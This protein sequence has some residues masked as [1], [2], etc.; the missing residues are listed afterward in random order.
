MNKKHLYFLGI[1][2][3]GMVWIA[4]YALKQ[5]WQ[6]SGT[7]LEPSAVIDRLKLAGAD[8]HL[9]SDPA[10]I[11][12]GITEVVMT[13]AITPSAPHYPEYL[14]LQERKLP[15]SKRAEWVG[16]LT[17][18][19]Y[20]VAVA[21]SHGKTTVTAM[22]GWILEQAGLDP[23]VF[24]GTNMPVWQNQT[25]I[26][27][28]NILVLE[29]DEF[30]RSFHHFYPKMAV[31]LNIDQDHL[32]YYTGGIPEIT[33]AYHRFLRNLPSA[34][35][36]GLQNAGIVIGY[37]R[38]GNLRK[39]ARGFKYRF[40]WYDE[41]HLYPG[42]KPPQPGLIYRLN[43]TAAAKAAHELGVEHDVIKQA[44]ASFPGSGRRFEY[45]GQ[46]ESV[47]L[48]DDYGHHPTEIAATL[49]AIRERWPAGKTRVG[50]VYQPHQHARTALLLKE[51]GRAF[52]QNSPDRLILAP[53]Y[54]VSGRAEDQQI[55]S[56]AIA[57]QIKLKAPAGM[58]VTTAN[59]EAE[60]EQLV[61][62]E[63]KKEGILICMGAGSI[64]TLFD[65]WRYA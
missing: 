9:G 6:V 4:D 52:D 33:A 36:N 49:A 15:I 25:R 35:H 38:D 43:A 31:V 17:K 24:V 45:L 65:K 63:V 44:I 58:T 54:K 26:G 39:A 47:Q 22:L 57:D 29:A 13:S 59:S 16:K 46:W 19:M 18:Q 20:T 32:D 10:K 40:R 30:D 64:R 55:T 37:G 34:V 5:G 1:G 7:D 23:T 21:G 61:R 2:G 11:P 28:G 60:L 42:A 41:A 50:L 51:F 48:Y 3:V 12:E 8:I 53:I 56:Q 62:E 14:A 27:Q